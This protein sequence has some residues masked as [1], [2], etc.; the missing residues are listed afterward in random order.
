MS[1]LRAVGV[2]VDHGGEPVLRGVD[3][4]LEPGQLLGLVGRSGSGKSTLLRAVLG[5]Q[6]AAGHV[7]L[8][9]EHV[10]L[11]STR[12]RPG[13]RR[14]V[15][16]VPQDPAGSLDPRW[17]VGRIVAEPLRRLAVPG[18]HQALVAEALAAVG[19][20]GDFAARRP[21]DLSGGQAQRVAV[22]RALVSGAGY[23]LV[24]EPVSGLDPALRDDVLDL[25]A[26]LARDRGTAVLFVSH[27]LAAV[28]RLCPTTAVLADGVVVE[29]GPTRRLLTSPAS[30]A[31]AELAAALPDGARRRALGAVREPAG[32]VAT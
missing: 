19:L 23:L 21:G 30:A 8:D 31:A 11:V 3:L 18:E 32:S 24:D 6:T 26:G 17:R 27:D 22:A 13:F 2:R 29:Q 16:Y 15:Q 25:L 20:A 7:D 12:R 4:A 9:G 14:R 10:A 1:G 28:A 5:L